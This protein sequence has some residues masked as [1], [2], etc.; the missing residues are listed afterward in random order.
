MRDTTLAWRQDAC[1]RTASS[2]RALEWGAPRDEVD[3][4]AAGGEGNGADAGELA[5][6]PLAGEVLVVEVRVVD[7]GVE[8][9]P[10][11]ERFEDVGGDADGD[12]TAH[13]GRSGG[14][15]RH[16]SQIGRVAAVRCRASRDGFVATV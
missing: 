12:V 5:Q 14:G 10:V 6:G 3:G 2:T 16:P 13:A 1:A 9:G 8:E 11:D 7:V 4:A 15:W